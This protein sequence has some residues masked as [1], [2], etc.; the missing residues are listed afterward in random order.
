MNRKYTPE[1]QQMVLDNLAAG[2]YQ[3]V[4]EAA[5]K[6]GILKY[7]TVK[8]WIIKHNRPELLPKTLIIDVP[9]GKKK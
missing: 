4:T 3:S 8:K 9:K 6:N 5:H 7:E 1:F 2:H